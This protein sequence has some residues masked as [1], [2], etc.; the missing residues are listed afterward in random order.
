[1][2]TIHIEELK[3]RRNEEMAQAFVDKREPNIAQLSDEITVAE[4][5]NTQVMENGRTAQ[6]AIELI[7]KRSSGLQNQISTLDVQRTELAVSELERQREAAIDR[8]VQ[9]VASLGPVIA[10]FVAADRMTCRLMER[11]LSAGGAVHRELPGEYLYSRLKKERLPLPWDRTNQEQQF[12]N[13][14]IFPPEVAEIIRPYIDLQPIFA[15]PHWMNDE[16]SILTACEIAAE[17]LR[18]VGVAI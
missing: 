11:R 5:E 1:V 7:E 3:R 15:A 10:D 8:Y 16:E 2:H 9:I 14:T 18:K 12:R 4:T 6:I 17:K 13:I